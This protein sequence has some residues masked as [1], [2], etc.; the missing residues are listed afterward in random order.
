MENNQ[1]W[2]PAKAANHLNKILDTFY[3]AH[4]G[5]R[6]PVEIDSL[7]YDTA[8]L[9]GWSDPIIKIGAVNI[10]SFEGALFS[11]ESGTKWMIAFNDQ[12][13]S[14]G[15]ILFTKA[16]ELGHYILHRQQQQEFLCNKHDMLD[17]ACGRDIE[18]EADKFA[19]YLLMP[20][21][22]FRKQ[23]SDAVCLEVFK[24]CANRY[25]VS[26]TAAI[27]KWLSYTKEKA[28]MVMSNDGFINWASC[29]DTAFKAGA[30]FRSRSETIPTPSGSLAAN[31][32]ITSELNGVN[33][34][35]KVW[36]R[37]ADTDSP[38]VEMKLFS[39]QFDSTISLLIL[40]KYCD[41][42]PRK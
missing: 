26:L 39:E 10:P 35:T 34:P 7:A 11:N 9:F 36:F 17:W 40:P 16:H 33:I 8:K 38:L 21:N 1:T 25:G 31:E 2:T 41:C 3:A 14:Q 12:L 6:F 32:S 29:S 20:L 15:R 23:I 18:K 22:D 24:H 13:A 42:W 30:F 28:V 27:L 5:D 4:G 37:H 19:S